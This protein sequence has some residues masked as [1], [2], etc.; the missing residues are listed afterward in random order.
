MS[1]STPVNVQAF[2]PYGGGNG[3]R[4]AASSTTTRVAIPGLEG[5]QQGDNSRVLITNPNAFSAFIRLGTSVVE[6]TLSSLEILAGTQVLLRPPFNG[7]A[8]AYMAVILESGTGSISVCSG[9]GT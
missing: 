6:A 3:A 9:A 2:E 7:P 8:P 4:I 5:G 1:E